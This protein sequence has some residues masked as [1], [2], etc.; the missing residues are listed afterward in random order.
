MRNK[1]AP[2]KKCKKDSKENKIRQ[3]LL[4]GNTLTPLEALNYFRHFRLADVV[5]D[6][7]REGINVV[8]LNEKFRNRHAN[9][10][11]VKS[12]LHP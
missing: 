5:L 11:V 10:Q 7:R 3:C 4:N 8:N 6:M 12:K 2:P 1:F 9:Y